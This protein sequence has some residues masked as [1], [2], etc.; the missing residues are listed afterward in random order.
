MPWDMVFTEFRKTEAPPAPSAKEPAAAIRVFACV[1]GRERSADALAF[2]PN[3]AVKVPLPPGLRVPSAQ[4]GPVRLGLAA[5][6]QGTWRRVAEVRGDIQR[7]WITTEK[8]VGKEGLFRLDLA[9]ESPEKKTV[10]VDAFVLVSSDWKRDLLAHCR[11]RRE[12]I[13]MDPNA[14]PMDSS[15]LT[16][17]WNHVMESISD[18]AVLSRRVLAAAAEA[19]RAHTEYEAGKRPGLVRGLNHL[20]FTRFPGG[21]TEEFVVLVPESY[22]ASKAWPMYV[23]PDNRRFMARD[24][25]NLRSGLIDVWWHTVGDDDIDWKSFLM[26]MNLLRE[27]LNLDP[28]RIY[29]NG[30]CHDGLAAMSLALTRPDQWAECSSSLTGTHHAL[31]S[32]ALN[33]N[34]IFVKGGHNEP[35]EPGYYNFTAKCFEYF[36]CDRFVTSGTLTTEQARGAKVPTATR[37]AQPLRVSYSIASL[38]N[39]Q[40][41]WV[42]IDGRVDENS[43]GRLEARVQGQTIQVTTKNVDAYTL[44]LNQAPVNLTEGVEIIENGMRVG[45]SEGKAPFRR[46]SGKYDRALYCKDERV[47]GPVGDVFSDAYAVI[48]GRGGDEMIR[49]ASDSMADDLLH[50]APKYT[51]ADAPSGLVKTHNLVLAGVPAPGSWVAKLYAGVPVTVTPEEIRV[52]GRRFPG[53]NIGVICVY[54]NPLNSEKYVAVF[55]GNSI[56]ATIALRKA[57]EQMKSLRPADVGI[58]RIL[59][60]GALDW[61]VFERF[62]TVW[63]WHAAW[64]Q[65]LFALQRKHPSWQWRQWVARLL[66]EQFHSDVVICDNPLRFE[67]KIPV[68]PVSYRDLANALVDNWL[69]KVE[70][71]GAE[72][73]QVILSI[74]H[75]PNPPAQAVE[76]PTVDGIRLQKPGAAPSGPSLVVGGLKNDKRYSLVCDRGWLNGARTGQAVF[77]YRLLDE[78]YLIEAVRSRVLRAEGADIDVQLDQ[79]PMTVN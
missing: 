13:E 14:R 10:R 30:E 61:Q 41:Y 52:V 28:E 47:H 45:R 69:V 6:A 31:A 48:V 36:G 72:L 18:T 67:D 40:A 34:M 11:L 77:D 39:P 59:R 68:G 53:T 27:K 26:L 73:R 79:F 78:G 46:R 64:D 56:R 16:S 51:D 60:E 8:G 17:Y 54:P 21:R 15:I 35:W 63:N 3:K 65:K 5:W 25:Y 7:E 32:N 76:L 2:P 50:G 44:S 22:T 49:Q 12:Q 4:S 42:R 24:R 57:W 29:V 1:A 66:R 71:S 75:P 58:F 33:L 38:V 23:H 55:L 9:L 19:Q 62:D 37:V 70:L 20:R 43:I 74:G